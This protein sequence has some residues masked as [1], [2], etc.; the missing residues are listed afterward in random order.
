M[1]Q[2]CR[3]LLLFAQLRSLAR[4]HFSHNII[5]THIRR[6]NRVVDND[7]IIL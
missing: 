7:I 6:A 4:L 2:C 5:K 1:L 3:M